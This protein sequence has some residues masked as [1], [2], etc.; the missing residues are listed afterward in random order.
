VTHTS[1]GKTDNAI[2]KTTKRSP[3]HACPAEVTKDDLVPKSISL[4]LHIVMCLLVTH[5]VH[6]SQVSNTRRIAG[7][8]VIPP[9]NTTNYLH[10]ITNNAHLQVHGQP[11]LTLRKIERLHTSSALAP[12]SALQQHNPISTPFTHAHKPSQQCQKKTQSCQ[13]HQLMQTQGHDCGSVAALLLCNP[14]HRKQTS[15]SSL[16]HLHQAAGKAQGT[17]DAGAAVRRSI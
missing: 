9:N 5:T 11:K 13:S 16:R 10:T 17:N 12:L 4:C 7:G 2:I 3:C 14:M 15:A 8:A 6:K 1:P